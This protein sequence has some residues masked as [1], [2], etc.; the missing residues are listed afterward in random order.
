[1]NRNSKITLALSASAFAV[2]VTAVYGALVAGEL[3][4]RGL[5][6]ASD[7]TTPYLTWRDIFFEGGSLRDW[8]FDKSSAPNLLTDVPFLWAI[9][10]ASGNLATGT[11]LFGVLM[12]VFSALGWFFVA[13]FIFGKTSPRRPLVF[14]LAALMCVC[15]AYGSGDLFGSVLFPMC[16]SSTYVFIPFSLLLLFGAAG[17]GF[18]KRAGLSV[19][20]AA[21]CSVVFYSDPIFGVWFAAPAFAAGAVC[22]FL[23][24]RAGFFI[25][26]LIGIIAG[27]FSSR[28]WGKLFVEPGAVTVQAG[29]FGDIESIASALGETF[30]WF[31]EAALRHPLLAA[32]WVVFMALLAV[33]VFRGVRS[34]ENI[35]PETL[36]IL[37]FLV[38]CISASLAAPVLT[39]NFFIEELPET[40]KSARYFL[41]ALL[42]PLFAGW[43]F[44][45]DFAKDVS[46]RFA[47]LK[48]VL[49]PAL[50]VF[51]VAAALPDAFKLRDGFTE[52][53][54]Y[55]PP[56]VRCFDENARERNLKNGIATYWWAKSVMATS[57]NGVRIAQVSVYPDGRGRERLYRW[58]YQI[59]ERFYHGPFDFVVTNTSKFRPDQDFCEGQGPERCRSFSLKTDPVATYILRPRHVTD[60]FGR[61]PSDTFSCGGAQILVFNPP[62]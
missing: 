50:S 28:F 2:C 21:V 17:G 26:P 35:K 36:F 8:D 32:V 58:S 61:K 60:Y 46:G 57:K 1:M 45:P 34:R 39:G 55:Y 12:L 49:P 33:A 29:G 31:S 52:F 20:L 14:I 37:L 27:F 44:L 59:S 15:L 40:V 51:L 5:L 48:T 18:A 47:Y 30:V 53:T 56:L 9:Y 24:R 19:L 6:F 42:L 41:P 7:F 54:G 4:P 13:G 38:F 25:L 3:F 23:F 16:H 22:L 11:H 10:A 43:V 62:L